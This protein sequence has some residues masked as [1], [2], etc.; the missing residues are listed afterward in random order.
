MKFKRE[1]DTQ[2]EML[3]KSFSK[4]LKLLPIAMQIISYTGKNFW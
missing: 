3:L 1:E 4:S 2:N